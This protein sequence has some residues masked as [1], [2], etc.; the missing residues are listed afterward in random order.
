MSTSDLV[1]NRAQSGVTQW[2][3]KCQ[4]RS[5]NGVIKGMQLPNQISTLPDCGDKLD[6]GVNSDRIRE[7]GQ[8]GDEAGAGARHRKTH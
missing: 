7:R 2:I 5:Q 4:R 1:P 3:E 8:G 6:T